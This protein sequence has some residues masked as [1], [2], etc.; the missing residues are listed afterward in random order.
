MWLTTGAEMLVMT[1]STVAASNRNVPM[2]WKKPVIAISVLF[3][4]R[5]LRKK[6]AEEIV[7]ETRARLLIIP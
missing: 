3:E 2:W 4:S 7:W 6:G 5:M 1:S